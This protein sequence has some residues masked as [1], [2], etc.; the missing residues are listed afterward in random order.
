MRSPCCCCSALSLSP[1]QGLAFGFVLLRVESL[2]E[3]GKVREQQRP[4]G[5]PAMCGPSMHCSALRMSG[6]G[7]AQPVMPACRAAAGL[8]LPPQCA[9]TATRPPP[10]HVAADLKRLTRRLD[11][12]LFIFSAG[13]PDA[14]HLRRETWHSPDKV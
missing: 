8:L 3:E 2:A 6:G 13:L 4:A 1:V 5:E 14:L 12:T 10:L 11:G 7:H 9:L